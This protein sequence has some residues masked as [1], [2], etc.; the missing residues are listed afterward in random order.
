MKSCSTPFK[1]WVFLCRCPYNSLSLNFTK[2]HYDY[3][4]L[5]LSFY[6]FPETRKIWSLFQENSVKDSSLYFRKI[7]STINIFVVHWLFPWELPLCVYLLYLSPVSSLLLRNHF[8]TFSFL[9]ISFLWFPKAG[10]SAHAYLLRHIYSYICFYGGFYF[11]SIFIFL[12][13]FFLNFVSLFSRCLYCLIIY[14]LNFCISSLA[15]KK[16]H[17]GNVLYLYLH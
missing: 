3:D 12:L 7:S 11:D 6:Q 5:V 4:L 8:C 16:D 14:S 15:F 10:S 2:H 13:S 9:T 1:H 17:V